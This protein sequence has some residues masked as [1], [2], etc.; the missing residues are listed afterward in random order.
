M[1]LT[2]DG[3]DDQLLLSSAP[4]TAPPLT[5]AAWFRTSLTAGGT[6]AIITIRGTAAPTIEYFSLGLNPSAGG[7]EVRFEVSSALGG[8]AAMGGG[9]TANIW[10]HVAG[11]EIATNSR[12]VYLN[13]VSEGTETTTV[14]PL[15]LN[16]TSIA[17]GGLGS[18]RF[19]KEDL[20]DIAVWNRALSAGELA[21]LADRYAALFLPSGLVF[22][23]PLIR[24][25]TDLRGGILTPTGTTV[26]AHPPI[27]FPHSRR[28]RFIAGAAAATIAAP[29]SPMTFQSIVPVISA[30]KSVLPGTSAIDFA[31]QLPVV[32]AGKSILPG[33]GAIILTGIAAVISG[34]A[35]VAPPV[36][37]LVATAIAPEIKN[38]VRID[39]VTANI[40][41]TVPVPV[42]STGA[43]VLPGVGGITFNAVIPGVS[44]G[45]SVQV[46][47]AGQTLQAVIPAISAGASVQVAVQNMTLQAVIPVISGGA[48]VQPSA[49]S[50][51]LTA[52]EPTLIIGGAVTV[53]APVAT[54]T[55]ESSNPTVVA[56]AVAAS[57]YSVHKGTSVRIPSG[58]RE[59]NITVGDEEVSDAS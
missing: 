21:L 9:Y 58:V 5:M 26:S 48:S 33:T 16:E 41:L 32:S 13:G 38:A 3:T 42:V 39:A 44:T 1:A 15:L 30:G 43:S 22:Y 18:S 54:I 6:V 12:A 56:A 57:R 7:D 47:V 34:G 27:I 25:L 19:F 52:L 53:I 20:A 40:N 4:V 29:A 37:V 46:P 23:A 50:V 55:I 14:I 45:V 17:Q 8:A 36:A 10:N 24:D 59:E 31:S 28:H 51:V 49:V 2:F 35:S 11:V